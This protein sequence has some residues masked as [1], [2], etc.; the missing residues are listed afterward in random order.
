L[1][2][3]ID[4][5]Y[6][7]F[8]AMFSGVAGKAKDFKN[9]AKLLIC[10]RLSEYVSVH[11]IKSVYPSEMFEYIGFKDDPKERTINRNLGRIGKKAPFI[12]ENY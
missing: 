5:D 8:D 11:R 1:A 6:C 4:K 2:D 9:Y 7:V 12:L 3:K 10:N